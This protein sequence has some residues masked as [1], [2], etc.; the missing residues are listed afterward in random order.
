MYINNLPNIKPISKYNKCMIG[1]FIDGE[2]TIVK[3]KRK[4]S[5]NNSNIMK[6]NRY[7]PTTSQINTHLFIGKK[8]YET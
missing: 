6:D 4:H 8:F 5:L 7:T 1:T 3:S 2:Y